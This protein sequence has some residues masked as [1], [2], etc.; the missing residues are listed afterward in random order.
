MVYRSDIDGLRAVAIISVVCFHAGIPYFSGGYVGVDVFFVVSGFLITGIIERDLQKNRFSLLDFYERRA[1]RI[2]PALFAMVFVCFVVGWFF[3]LD[4]QFENLGR[5]AASVI[6]FYSNI[7][8]WFEA[9]NYFAA[10]AELEPL[11]HTWSLAVEEQFYLVFPVILIIIRHWSNVHRITLISGLALI[12]FALSLFAVEFDKAAAFYLAP[13]RFFELMI[14]SLLAMGTSRGRVWD[15]HSNSLSIAGIACIVVAIVFYDDMTT[16]PGISALLPALGAA[17]VIYSGTS[18]QTI[19]SRCLSQR[20]IVFVGLIS[21]SLYLWHWPILAFLRV[22]FGSVDLPNSVMAAAIAVSFILAWLSWRFIEQPIRDKRVVRPKQ[23]LVMATSGACCILALALTV[24][25]KNGLP[26]RIPSAARLLALAKQDSNPRRSA[27]F[28]VWP[29]DGLCRLGDDHA[30]VSFVFWGDSHADA[31]VPALDLAAAR[32]GK[33]GLFVG[34]SACPPLLG[35]TPIQSKTTECRS[36]NDAVASMLRERSDIDH[37]ILT[38]RWAV[39]AEASPIVAGSSPTFQLFDDEDERGIDNLGVFRRG[40]RRTLDML[41]AEEKAITILEGVPEIGWDVPTHLAHASWW[42][43]D[44]PAVPD[45]A[46]VRARN[47]HVEQAFAD[48]AGDRGVALVPMA[49]LLCS[50]DCIVTHQGK[51]IYHDGDHITLHA[52]KTV[53]AGPLKERIWGENF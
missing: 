12:S 23:V 8:F 26:E 37:V 9:K 20:P 5:S 25:A 46:D 32:S 19:I 35:V 39:Y 2:L 27:C 22:R 48:L 6:G 47:A 11:L 1:R 44:L 41:A 24:W 13:S 52:A 40:L 28:H 53:F 15:G 36:F 7:H 34:S 14:G 3:L 4:Q 49:D 43:D 45:R 51:P 50:P 42:G 18:G 33:A 31:F 17:L 16:F 10:S 21:Y 30:P 29:E 38:A